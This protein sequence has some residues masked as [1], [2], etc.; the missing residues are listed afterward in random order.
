MLWP[1]IQSQLNSFNVKGKGSAF[2]IEKDTFYA[3]LRSL[4]QH[5]VVDEDWYLDRNQDIREAIDSKI[6]KSAKDHFV[7]FGYFEGKLP[8]PVQVDEEFYLTRYPDVQAAILSGA[9]PDAQTHFLMAGA[10]EGRMPFEGFSLFENFS[11][12]EAVRQ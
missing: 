1:T 12:E 10:K 3:L 6:I 8:Y 4:L 9:L 7:R 5:V 2:L 11:Q